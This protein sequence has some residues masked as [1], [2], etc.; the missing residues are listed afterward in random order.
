MLCEGNKDNYN[1]ARSMMEKT[2]DR[3]EKSPD[4]GKQYCDQFNEYVERGVF[5]EIPQAE[6]SNYSG[7]RRYATHHEVYKEDSA[8]CDWF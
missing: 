8:S 4:K 2:E 3:L 7:P 5:K 6:L 1:Q